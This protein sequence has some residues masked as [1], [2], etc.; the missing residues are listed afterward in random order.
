MYRI[1]TAELRIPQLGTQNLEVKFACSLAL[2]L[3]KCITIKIQPAVI[4]VCSLWFS[5]TTNQFEINNSK[6]NHNYKLFI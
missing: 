4:M 2:E 1:D 3:K 6:F 5:T